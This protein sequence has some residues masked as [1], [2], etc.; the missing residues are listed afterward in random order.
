MNVQDFI[1]GLAEQSP[2]QLLARASERLPFWIS[3]GLV[4]MIAWYLARLVWALY[5][6]PADVA[7]TPP[8]APAAGA[9]ADPGPQA[10]YS[11]LVAA[12]LFGE[13]SAEPAPVAEEVVDAPDTRLNLELRATVAAT[14][15]QLML[16]A[17]D[18]HFH[19]VISSTS[20]AP[21]A[22][23]K[24]SVLPPVGGARGGRNRRFRQLVNAPCG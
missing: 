7:W 8:A 15:S 21:S 19:C 3:L 10:D 20:L 14:D 12:K 4:V 24:H 17:G 6:P 1:T 23:G 22:G 2:E 16:L 13:A 11:A 9:A 18:D 5:P